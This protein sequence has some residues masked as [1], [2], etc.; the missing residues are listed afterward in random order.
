MSFLRGFFE[1]IRNLARAERS[2]SSS[3]P[4]V[5]AFEVGVPPDRLCSEAAGLVLDVDRCSE[6]VGCR[7]GSSGLEDISGLDFAGGFFFGFLGFSGKAAFCCLLADAP[8]FPVS[9]PL[10][11]RC[12]SSESK[13]AI[14]LLSGFVVCFATFSDAAIVACSLTTSCLMYFLASLT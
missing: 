7:F 14:V 9:D 10:I 13:D 6:T 12:S 11:P 4:D 8:L 5:E 3:R 2:G 1:A